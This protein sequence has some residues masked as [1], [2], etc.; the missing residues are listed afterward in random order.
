[1]VE[2][3]CD[4]STYLKWLV[5]C[6]TLNNLIIFVKKLINIGYTKYMYIFYDKQTFIFI[7]V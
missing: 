6:K 1:M 2:K 7:H 5:I 4:V 3:K